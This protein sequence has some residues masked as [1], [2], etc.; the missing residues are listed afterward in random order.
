MKSTITRLLPAA[1]LLAAGLTSGAATAASVAITQIVEHP[2]LDAC[3]QGVQDELAERGFVVGQ[4]LEWS[5]ESAQGSPTTAAQVA[6]KF[7]GLGP[8]VIV[9]ISTPSAQ[10]VASAARS[11]PLIFSA[12]TDPVGAK[13]VSNAAKPGGLITG[14]S[15][16]TP[17]GAHMDLV[18]RVV[19]SATRVGVI[20]NPGEANSVTLVGLVN[21]HA[22]AKG[23]SVVEAG[24]TKSSDVLSA[25]RSLVGKVDA[26]YIPTDN[27]VISALEAV[28]KVGSDAKIPVITGDTDSVKRGA[29]AALGFNYYDVGRQTGVMVARVL[30]GE[31]PGD[32]AVEGVS[33]L[34]LFVNPAAAAAMGATLPAGMEDEAKEVI[35]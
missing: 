12:V 35:R 31:K 2:A 23:M 6:K 27:T 34:E 3:R 24:A 11:T 26:I 20:Y 22:P 9:A 28:L 14:V 8:D 7:A 5:Y 10:T 4:N 32:I 1:V 29:V 21:E 17:I 25:A 13:L 19:P 15:D 16:L 33:K 18:K 30:N